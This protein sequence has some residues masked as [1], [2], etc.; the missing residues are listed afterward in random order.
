MLKSTLTGTDELT[1]LVLNQGGDL[2]AI[3]G[4]DNV[5]QAI[6]IKFMTERKELPAHPKF[7]AKY[8]IGR[9]ATPSSFNEL[10]INTLNTLA[11]D[12]RI[13][14]VRNLQFLSA[15]DKLAA[16]VD[17]VLINAR[18]ILSTSLALRRF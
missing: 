14:Q 17:L 18:G 13:A 10:R 8:A 1:D 15:G 5:Q 11:S 7:G 12:T 4:T 16:K 3:Q 9:K 2:A 6:R